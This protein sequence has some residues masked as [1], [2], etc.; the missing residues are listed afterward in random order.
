M[1]SSPRQAPA[2]P[3]PKNAF[4]AKMLDR[5]YASMATGPSINCRPGNSRQRLDLTLLRELEGPTPEELIATLLGDGRKVTYK[6]PLARAPGA[7]QEE[8]GEERSPEARA[9]R[10]RARAQASVL[11]KLS[12]I[13]DDALTFENETGAQVLFIGLPLL[14][15]PP[16]GAGAN[17]LLSRRVLAPIAFIPVKLTVKAGR[18]PVIELE[19]C[20]A[21]LDR[22][23]SNSAL[24]TWLEQQTGHALRELYSADEEVE[25]WEELNGLLSALAAAL[26]LPAPAAL[27][28]VTLRLL[29]ATSA[30]EEE[31]ESAAELPIPTIAQSAVLGLFPLPNQNLIKDMEALAEGEA[32]QGPIESF[33]KANSSFDAEAQSAGAA[34]RLHDDRLVTV[35][36]PCQARAVRL[37]RTS[38][39]LVIHG[40]PGSGKSQTIANM[41]GDHLCRG[42]RVLF[43][44]DKRTALDVV[45]NRLDALGLGG[46]CAVVHD[47]RRDQRELYL[48]IREQLDALPERSAQGAQGSGAAERLARLDHELT[49]LHG[50]LAAHDRALAE[51]PTPA[52]H[53][54]RELAG[55]WLSTKVEEGLAAATAP[56]SQARLPFSALGG[57]E[58]RCREL[59]ARAQAAAWPKSPLRERFAFEPKLARL[60]HTSRGQ[61]EPARLRSTLEA[62]SSASRTWHAVFHFI[63][64]RR[65]IFALLRFGLELTDENLA[66]ALRYLKGLEEREQQP[67][68][69]GETVK[70]L[71]EGLAA[72]PE[73][74]GDA[75]CA[76][77]EIGVG[78]EE[79][80]QALRRAVATG[81]LARRLE[82]NPALVSLDSQRLQALHNR[83]RDL[84]NA[85]AALVREAVADRWFVRQRARLLAAT[86]SR[87]NATATE[88][89]RRL[90]LRGERAMKVRQV[91]AAGAGIE[92]GDPLFDLRPVWMASPGT[93]AQLFP[94]APLFDV[95]I[96]DES[97]QCRLEEAI[98]VLTRARRTVIAGDPKQLPPTRFFES[99]IAQ[100]EAAQNVA[101][102]EQSLFEEQQGDV[103]DLLGA[104][105]NLET[106]QAFLDVHYRSENGDLIAFSNQHFYESRLQPLPARPG[107][108]PPEPPV[109]LIHAGGTYEKRANPR[110]AEV[111]VN[112]VRALLERP[113][114]PSIG[115]ACFN[116]TQRDAIA[117]ALD[118]AALAEPAFGARLAEA[119]ARRSASSFEGL[120][121]KNLENVQGDERDHLIISTTYGPDAKGKFRRQ[122][123]PLGQ[124]GGGR[125]LNVLITRARKEVHLVTSIPRELYRALPP[126][127]PGQ[128]PGG[129]YLLLAYLKW[130]EELACS[131]GHI[132]SVTP[133]GVHLASLTAAPA[134]E[135]SDF[136]SA[137]A[138]ELARVEAYLPALNVG[139]EGF[140]ID[141]ALRDPAR[142][143]LAPLGLLCDRTRYAK[144]PDRIEWDLFRAATLERQGWRV[145]RLWTPEFFRDP[146]N[147]LKQI[148]QALSGGR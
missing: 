113:T 96:F 108:R 80:W 103:E 114:P 104:A 81:E 85:R 4:V 118:E 84:E 102:D 38:R 70:R 25:P 35:A 6:A 22:I 93:V 13:A 105:L 28:P 10:A 79:G 135:T 32:H 36:D 128:T 41:I 106:E 125:R 107:A 83:Y 7:A 5:L 1:E 40:P 97:S 53:S 91:I 21:G 27:T 56:L 109:R 44:C 121:V 127:E 74:L 61:S 72:L 76:L 120:F 29:P 129:G 31:G 139:N 73:P 68:A 60:L 19:S 124:A 37:A 8:E 17:A 92:G 137:L 141:I 43:V 86:G 136:P 94:R 9:L 24:M 14:S 123:G 11:R 98:P 39:S 126:L 16:G 82:E 26:E 87:L 69:G 115:I 63:K 112:I 64:R 132:P 59:L 138:S 147:Q 30:G 110:E 18:V 88:V 48:A 77:F 122:F 142:A 47:A 65:A 143:E 140:R 133:T 111:V 116:L 42:E 57:W 90:M 15:I 2:A 3:P 71:E 119:R 130:A 12:V 145:M 99:A 146:P 51:R 144:A 89:K 34:R 75:L 131:Y 20:G 52:E 67:L 66:R 50:E 134:V 100:S 148:R 54:F 62:Y 58:L 95:V 33:L 55:L 23:F 49:A 117:E 46:L 101:E 45:K 78:E